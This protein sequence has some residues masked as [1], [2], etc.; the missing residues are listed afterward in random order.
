M[1]RVKRSTGKLL[2]L[3]LLGV[4]LSACLLLDILAGPADIGWHSVWLALLDPA[5]LPVREQVIIWDVRLPDALIAVTVGAALGLSGLETQTVLNN[6]LASPFTLGISAFAGLGASVGIVFAGALPW[7]PMSAAVPTLALVGALVCTLLVLLFA[8]WQGE[9]REH[10][11][12]FGMALFF[13]GNALTAAIQFVATSEAVDQIV[14]WSIG[15]LTRAGWWENGMVALCFVLLLPWSAR[16]AAVLTLLRAGEAQAQSLGLDLARLRLWILLRVSVLCAFAVCF[17]GIIAFVG[18]IGPHMARFLLGEDHRFLIPGAILCGA[19]VLS[20]AS[21][22]SKVLITG[23][24]IPV[25]I[26]TSLV[27]V[28]LFLVLMMTRG[29]SV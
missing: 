29:R 4:A 14:F 25:G 21:L 23:V 5:L 12:L 10:I 3:V 28:P 6:P 20:L 22:L 15:D 9:G 19:L 8:N 17:V 24:I 13:L 27:G 16:Q 7:L 2:L 26:I 18:L 1:K 11:V